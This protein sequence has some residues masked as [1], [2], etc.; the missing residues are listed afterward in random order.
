VGIRVICVIRVLSFAFMEVISDLKNCDGCCAPGLFC[1]P[2]GFFNNIID[3]GP[4]RWSAGIF[5]TGIV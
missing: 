1:F 3:S 4:G 5:I 2:A